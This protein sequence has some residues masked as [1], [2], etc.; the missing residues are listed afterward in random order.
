MVPGG[1]VEPP[2]PEGRRILSST[3]GSERLGKFSTLLDSSTAYQHVDSRCHD[4]FHR[5]LNVELLQFYYSPVGQLITANRTV[6]KITQCVLTRCEN[7][8]LH[9]IL[10]LFTRNTF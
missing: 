1:G 5:V 2:R 3:V 6:L 8:L 4:P 7:S 9:L 10:Q